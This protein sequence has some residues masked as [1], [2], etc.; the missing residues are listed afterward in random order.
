MSS[1]CGFRG[2]GML[3][4]CSEKR[5]EDRFNDDVFLKA[6]T[7]ALAKLQLRPLSFPLSPL[8]FS[9]SLSSAFGYAFCAEPGG[10]EKNL[11]CG[12]IPG[13]VVQSPCRL[14][15]ARISPTA[16]SK[17]YLYI[18]EHRV[19]LYQHKVCVHLQRAGVSYGMGK[20][21]S[22]TVTNWMQSFGINCLPTPLAAP[23]AALVPSTPEDEDEEDTLDKVLV[24]LVE[25]ARFGS[26]GIAGSGESESGY[27]TLFLF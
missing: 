22:A 10:E 21:E 3:G 9:F 6:G 11:G 17:L 16:S 19:P 26:W 2:I 7:I 1:T 5:F 12:G 23:S 24:G 20:R 8:S 25:L 13:S 4:G 15:Q 18:I 14:P 27:W